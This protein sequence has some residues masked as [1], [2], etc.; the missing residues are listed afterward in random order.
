MDTPGLRTWA[1]T[2]EG[3]FEGFNAKQPSGR[4]GTVDEI[5]NAAVF[6]ASDQASF[7]NGA[8]IPVDGAVHAILAAPV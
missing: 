4:V 1:E 5:A 7:I 6:I 8:T 2:L 3:G